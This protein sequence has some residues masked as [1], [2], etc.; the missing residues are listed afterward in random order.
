MYTD[1]LFLE[2]TYL[3]Q[4][5]LCHCIFPGDYLDTLENNVIKKKKDI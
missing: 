3:D 4:P 2:F 1:Y 5:L